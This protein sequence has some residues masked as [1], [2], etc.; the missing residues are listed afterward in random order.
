MDTK[1]KRSFWTDAVVEEMPVEQK[2][3]LLW[4]L[5]ANI[6]S[7]GWAPVTRRRFE[8]ET[9]SPWEAL[10]QAVKAMGKGILSHE[11]GFWIRNYIRHQIG[12]GDR[13]A[14]NNMRVPITT[15]LSDVPEDI[16]PQILADYPCLASPPEALGKG[17]PSGVPPQ[18][19]RR[20]EDGDGEKKSQGE[21]GAGRRGERPARPSL[22]Q[23]Q[24][25]AGQAGVTAEEA[26][27]WWHTR[28]GSGWVKGSA[29][30]G[31]TPVGQ[32]WVSD[33][34]TF[35]NQAR[36]RQRREEVRE[37]GRVRETTQRVTMS[38]R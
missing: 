37:T 24:A 32:N 38:L 36:E 33:L 2:L 17:M 14:K 11:K 35:T 25:K 5:T 8:F 31:T 30:G 1:I 18:E 19:Q 16:R 27:E 12:D 23:A 26:E 20:E 4:L 28:E 7:C 3:A 6:S 29:G 10:L 34:K 21:E 13:L 9:G 22:Q 15:S